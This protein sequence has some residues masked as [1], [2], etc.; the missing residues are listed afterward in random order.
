MMEMWLYDEMLFS[1]RNNKSLFNEPI[2]SGYY[3]SKIK[4]FYLIV[5]PYSFYDN[6]EMC[7]LNC[8]WTSDSSTKQS[9]KLYVTSEQPF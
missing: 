4:C 7:P 6:D 9:H 8:I 3:Q 5:L 2:P 1:F